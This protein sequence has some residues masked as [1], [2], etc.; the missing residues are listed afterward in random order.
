MSEQNQ[1]WN[2]LGDK[3]REHQDKGGD[4]AANYARLR[5][6]ASEDSTPEITPFS[7]LSLL[8]GAL[9][10][11]SIWGNAYQYGLGTQP[12]ALPCPSFTEEL[13][14]QQSKDFQ[15]KP[16]REAEAVEVSLIS[17]N[18]DKG[19]GESVTNREVYTTTIS[20][21]SPEKLPALIGKPLLSVQD[22]EQEVLLSAPD[23]VLE[24]PARQPQALPPAVKSLE[25]AVE[26]TEKGGVQKSTRVAPD[27]EPSANDRASNHMVAP[28]PITSYGQGMMEAPKPFSLLSAYRVGEMD[29]RGIVESKKKWF[30]LDD[31][32][33]ALSFNAGL[34]VS[35]GFPY[36]VGGGPSLTS[37]VQLA[38]KLFED[39]DGSPV[40]LEVGFFQGRPSWLN[41]DNVLYRTE[42]PASLL[43]D[44]APEEATVQYEV[45]N[46]WGVEIGMSDFSQ[47]TDWLGIR[48][49]LGLSILSY[50]QRFEQTSGGELLD[51][52]V[53]PQLAQPIGMYWY[54]GPELRFGKQGHLRIS[55]HG[56]V[57]NNARKAYFPG[58]NNG[59]EGVAFGLGWGF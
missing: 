50:Q 1:D 45:Y 9:L 37:H 34:R 11:F 6:Q 16:L 18:S 33:T 49:G 2:S 47:L 8:L 58:R 28:L 7:N 29:L 48:S 25:E 10:I 46:A 57:G 54:V 12:T 41:Q 53:A 3:L 15:H 32:G 43:L 5:E 44:S 13:Q 42:Q 55:Y 26:S 22:T 36:Q 30:N 31:V 14:G 19:M 20:T 17:G 23:L 21:K 38:Y 35:G 40:G 52:S 24:P 56:L 59:L 27:G 39:G 51:F 4:W